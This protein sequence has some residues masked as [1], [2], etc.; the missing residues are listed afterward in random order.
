[1]NFLEDPELESIS[2]FL[3]EKEL[4]NT[5]LNGKIE[6]YSIRIPVIPVLPEIPENKPLNMSSTDIPTNFENISGTESNMNVNNIN[7]NNDM[8]TSVTATNPPS[9]L[10]SIND[11]NNIEDVIFNLNNRPSRS[12]S[13]S[14]TDN[15][16]STSIGRPRDAKRSS[17]LGDLSTPSSK[18]LFFN[19]ISTLNEAFP[20]YDFQSTKLDQFIESDLFP[21]MRS[22]NNLLVDLK[23]ISPNFLEKLWHSIDQSVNLK[24]SIVFCYKSDNESDPFSQVGVSWSFN[25]FFFNAQKMKICY[26]TCVAKR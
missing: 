11:Q 6:A 10:I 5:I 23:E 18:Q 16:F 24:H 4:N 26:F 19:L 8:A 12:R 13:N 14:V 1:M 21:T 25:Y 2:L 7:K 22:I 20:D 17:S 15:Y 9:P 3:T